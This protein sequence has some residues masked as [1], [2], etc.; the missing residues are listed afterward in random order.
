MKNAVKKINA[1]YDIPG[2]KWQREGKNWRTEHRAFVSSDFEEMLQEALSQ[3][4]EID[5]VDRLRR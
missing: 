3:R 1:M 5:S 2:R 4:K